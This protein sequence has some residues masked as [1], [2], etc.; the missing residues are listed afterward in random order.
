MKPVDGI[1]VVITFGHYESYNDQTILVSDYIYEN[2]VMASIKNDIPKHLLKYKGEVLR[3]VGK[4]FLRFIVD[5]QTK[6]KESL[7]N[8]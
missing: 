4:A 5:Y 2:E 8:G 3:Q 6:V 1:N 7:T